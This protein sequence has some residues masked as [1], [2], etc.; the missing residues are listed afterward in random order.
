M[1]ATSNTTTKTATIAPGVSLSGEIDIEGFKIAAIEMPAAWTAANLTFQ[2]ASA[3]GG[4]FKNVHDDAGTEVLVTA[5]ADRI[6]GLDAILPELAA[7]RF[8]KIRSGTA[9]IPVNQAA[10]M[11][12]T[13]IL[14]G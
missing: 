13:L 8:L 1:G 14:K 5:A 10:A 11:T 3:A 9:A 2:A 6:I 7:I 12:L 4:T